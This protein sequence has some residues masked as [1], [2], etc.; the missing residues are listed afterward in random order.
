MVEGPSNI[1]VAVR[2]RPLL[3]HEQKANHTTQ[4]M[5]V[6]TAEN[7]IEMTVNDQ[8]RNQAVR[9]AY[10]FDRIIDTKFSQEE[11]FDQL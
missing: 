3:D 1:R 7:K 2:V 11:V 10:A 5:N 6:N 4:F 9:K 8:K